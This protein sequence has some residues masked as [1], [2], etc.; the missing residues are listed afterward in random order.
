MGFVNFNLSAPRL[1]VSDETLNALSKE[2]QSLILSRQLLLL[3]CGL[4]A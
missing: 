3:I 4:A 2:S 1:P